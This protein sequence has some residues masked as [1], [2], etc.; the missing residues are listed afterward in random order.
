M[1]VTLLPDV[2]SI[3]VQYLKAHDDVLELVATTNIASVYNPKAALPFLQVALV[4][5]PV[6]VE[7]HLVR[8]RIQLDGWAESRAASRDLCRTA[9]AAMVELTG[10][11]GGSGVVTDVRTAQ[12]P[13]PLYD[14]ARE[15]QR[16][17]ADVF[18]WV[19]VEH[20]VP[21]S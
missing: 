16:F 7:R 12:G 10:S 2:E 1:S 9:H 5:E 20:D 14:P 21:G 18:V 4:D 3:A 17:S 6:I 11:Q 15:R 19:H 13:R 8:A